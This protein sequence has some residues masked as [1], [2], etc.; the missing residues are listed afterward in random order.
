MVGYFGAGGDALLGVIIGEGAVGAELRALV[1][2]VIRKGDLSV[3][4]VQ[5]AEPVRSV[6]QIHEVSAVYCHVWAGG[7]AGEV[8]LVA[9]ERTGADGQALEAP[10]IG[11]EQG[12]AGA[13]AHADPDGRVGK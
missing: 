12:R 2:V 13:V 9:E 10:T 7:Q 8:P 6:R 11:V 4:A 5:H 1:V 3:D